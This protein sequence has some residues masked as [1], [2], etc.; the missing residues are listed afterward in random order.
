MD[1]RHTCCCPIIVCPCCCIGAIV[2]AL[3]WTVLVAVPVAPDRPEMA[4]STAATPALEDRDDATALPVPATVLMV[5]IC[6]SCHLHEINT[7]NK[8]MRIL[9]KTQ[10]CFD[11][12]VVGYLGSHNSGGVRSCP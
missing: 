11:L 9:C 4:P 5:V 6:D 2:G 3:V 8:I 7:T 10:T 12:V 1:C